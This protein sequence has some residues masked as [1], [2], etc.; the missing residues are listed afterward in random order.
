[1]RTQPKFLIFLL[2]SII[3]MSSCKSHRFQ[4]FNRQKFLKGQ[5][6]QVIDEA[7][8]EEGNVS[9]NE[10]EEFTSSLVFIEEEFVGDFVLKNT[11]GEFAVTEFTE[12][13]KGNHENHENHKNITP[14]V[15]DE[16]DEPELAD[17]EK[18]RVPKLSA[19]EKS[20]GWEGLQ[21]L[22]LIIVFLLGLGITFLMSWAFSPVLGIGAWVIGG[23]L[24]LLQLW[25]MVWVFFGNRPQ[26]D[27]TEIHAVWLVAVWELLVIQLLHTAI[28]GIAALISLLFK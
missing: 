24:G 23:I 10:N 8:I 15:A 1:M 26:W 27:G 3:L 4:N 28:Q 5:I 9:L 21:I 14:E 18:V 2:L 22:G 19:G 16:R 11:A 17:V 13:I 25:Y 12:G 20:D 6:T 7:K